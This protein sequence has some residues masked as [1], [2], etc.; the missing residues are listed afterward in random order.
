VFPPCDT[1]S[2]TD[3]MKY[4]HRVNLP[5]SVSDILPAGMPRAVV[6]KHPCWWLG[7][8]TGVDPDVV[9]SE[10]NSVNKTQL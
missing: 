9:Y 6:T 5:G 10:V 7:G 8:G 1:F 2:A 4:V 3:I